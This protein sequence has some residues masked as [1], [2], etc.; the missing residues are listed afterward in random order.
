MAS[1]QARARHQEQIDA[2]AAASLRALTGVPTGTFAASACPVVGNCCRFMRCT[3]SRCRC[4]M[5]SP[6]SVALQTAWRCVCAAVTPACMRDSHPAMRSNACCSDCSNSSAPSRWHPT[7]CF[8]CAAI[9]AMLSRP[10]RWPFTMPAGPALRKACCCTPSSRSV[11]RGSLAS[12]WWT[13]PKT[14]WRRRA[15]AWRH[16]YRHTVV[17]R[18]SVGGG[19]AAG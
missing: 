18:P 14:C 6:V 5:I 3:C 7:R 9:C 8:A 15:P 4:A 10:G 12:R 19:A 2:L 17:P 13:Q 16:G 1:A 11:T